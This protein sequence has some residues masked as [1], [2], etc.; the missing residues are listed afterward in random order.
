M[1][2]DVERQ[3]VDSL[4]IMGRGLV[5]FGLRHQDVSRRG[6]LLPDGEGTPIGA[7]AGIGGEEFVEAGGE[8]LVHLVVCLPVLVWLR[9]FR[10]LRREPSLRLV[11]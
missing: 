8:C 11:C 3:L 5:G 10:F 4:N 9:R 7:E 2:L 1:L 6:D